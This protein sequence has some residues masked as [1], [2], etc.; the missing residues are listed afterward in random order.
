MLFTEDLMKKVGHSRPFIRCS[1]CLACQA[2]IEI[3]LTRNRHLRNF[4]VADQRRNGLRSENS[5]PYGQA[6][7]LTPRRA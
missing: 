7:T 2:P 1:T 5:G 3:E 4:G 6:L